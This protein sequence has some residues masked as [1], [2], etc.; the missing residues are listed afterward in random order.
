MSHNFPP[1]TTNRIVQGVKI[2]NGDPHMLED[3]EFRY[4]YGKPRYHTET[5]EI[6]I[7]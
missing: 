6:I 7:D 1:S 3:S 2:V 5:G 4:I